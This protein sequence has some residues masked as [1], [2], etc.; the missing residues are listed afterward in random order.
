MSLSVA[1]IKASSCC[2]YWTAN[3]HVCMC[4]THLVIV[5]SEGDGA[6]AFG[7]VRRSDPS[8]RATGHGCAETA[9]ATTD[10]PGR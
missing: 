9:N 8:A 6:V 4:V 10:L 5:Q 7:D 2:G 3:V 1:C